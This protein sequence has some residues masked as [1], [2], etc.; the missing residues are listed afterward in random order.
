MLQSVPN[1][2][3]AKWRESEARTPRLQ[4][5]N[6]LADIIADQAESGIPDIFLDDCRQP[7]HELVFST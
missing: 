2:D 4:S 5:W 1:M 6:D 7:R 3:F